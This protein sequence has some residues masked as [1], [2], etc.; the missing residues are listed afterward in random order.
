M[1]ELN[2]DI[3]EVISNVNRVLEE[4]PFEINRFEVG[5]SGAGGEVINIDIRRHENGD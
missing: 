5:Q 1:V 4:S 3:I 2:K